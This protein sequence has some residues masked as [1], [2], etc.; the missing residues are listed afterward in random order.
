MQGDCRAEFALGLEEWAEPIANWGKWYMK[1][2]TCVPLR[3]PKHLDGE[4]SA[5]LSFL[6]TVNFAVA[7]SLHCDLYIRT[8]Y[9]LSWKDWK[10]TKTL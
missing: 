4:K 10:T 5:L 1:I 6:V 9:I 7:A 3:P 8:L 2:V